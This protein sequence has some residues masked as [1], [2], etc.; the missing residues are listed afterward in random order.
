MIQNI[1]DVYRHNISAN[2]KSIDKYLSSLNDKELNYVLDLM[3]ID[4]YKVLFY[5]R[6]YQDS[7]DTLDLIEERPDLMK[8]AIKFDRNILKSLIYGSTCFKEMDLINRAILMEELESKNKH[9]ILEKINKAHLLDKM[10]YSFKY[11]LSYFSDLYQD[12]INKYSEYD[13]VID[14]IIDNL[15]NLNIINYEKYLK[16]VLEFIK[17]YYKYSIYNISI[18]KK[19]RYLKFIEDSSLKELY[20]KSV[21]DYNFLYTILKTHLENS[22][23]REE[24]QEKIDNYFYSNSDKEM[25]KKL[26]FEHKK[27]SE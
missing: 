10:I 16:F 7:R 3:I 11:D 13:L 17:S 5:S 18:G 20:E 21:S 26:K 2:I 19:S 22:I 14:Y 24:E 9:K 12:Y 4:L 25:Q 1:N 6:L 23:S 8:R 15:N 27:T